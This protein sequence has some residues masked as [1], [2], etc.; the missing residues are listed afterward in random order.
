MNNRMKFHALGLVLLLAFSLTAC[1]TD[2]GVITPGDTNVRSDAG[3]TLEK[4]GRGQIWAGCTL[5]NT[6]GTPANFS[7]ASEPFDE[8]YNVAVSGGAFKD[9]IGAISESMPGD[10]DFNGGRWHVN[11]L[12]PGVSVNKYSTACSVEELD[13]DDFMGTS[14]YFECPL[15]PM[16][17]RP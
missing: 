6:V 2:E 16:N 5:F 13:L 4:V 17:R 14:I 12:K 10:M 9:G 1:N 3:V 15:I 8:L 7:P 11:V